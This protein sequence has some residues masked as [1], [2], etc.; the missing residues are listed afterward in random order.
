MIVLPP[1]WTIQ[2]MQPPVAEQ[3]LALINVPIPTSC[4]SD[5]SL[6]EFAIRDGW[7]VVVFYDCGGFDYIDSFV[8]PDG[9]TIDFWDWPESS[10]KQKLVNWSPS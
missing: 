8:S 9:K 2:T 10:D 4:V 3:L 5:D 1:G 7:K 6:I